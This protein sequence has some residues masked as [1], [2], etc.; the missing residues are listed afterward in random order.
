[1]Y[2]TEGTWG[3]FDHMLVNLMC[4]SISEEVRSA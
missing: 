2:L 4:F 1:M 3:N